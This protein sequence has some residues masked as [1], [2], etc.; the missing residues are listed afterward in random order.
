[1][2]KVT[3]MTFPEIGREV[4]VASISAMDH[5]RAGTDLLGGEASWLLGEK[6]RLSWPF[7]PVLGGRPG[8][9]APDREETG[10]GS[11]RRLYELQAEVYG[12][13]SSRTIAFN[14]WT[15]PPQ[16]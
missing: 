5:V 1:M 9:T 8:V 2:L 7:S 15:M 3:D 16:P 11:S 13:G 14:Y 4:L 10:M 12:P 6:Q